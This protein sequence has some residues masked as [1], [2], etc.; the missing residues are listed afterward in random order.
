[1]KNILAFFMFFKASITFSQCE[2]AFPINNSIM[3]FIELN[4][5]KKIGRGE[6]WDVAKGALDFAEATLVDVYEFGRLLEKNECIYP[7]DIIQFENVKTELSEEGVINYQNF[8]HHTAIVYETTTQD[9]IV[10]AHQNVDGKR[11]L[12]TSKF[13]FSSVTEGE[14]KVY[15]PID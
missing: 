15:R 5:G 7:G 2:E 11:K 8:P 1:M 10:L 12:T 13:V 6:C 4:M 9:D 3:E 14:L